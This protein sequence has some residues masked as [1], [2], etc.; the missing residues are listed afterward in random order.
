MVALE[1]QCRRLVI[2]RDS[3]RDVIGDG[4]AGYS[5]GSVGGCSGNEDEDDDEADVELLGDADE[6]AAALAAELDLLDKLWKFEG[7]M[8]A[9]SREVLRKTREAGGT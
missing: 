9:A 2:N 4:R 3:L 8:A 7:E 1:A 5:F 6:A